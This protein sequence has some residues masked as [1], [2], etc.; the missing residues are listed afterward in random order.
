MDFVDTSVAISENRI[1]AQHLLVM[2]MI[3]LS[4]DRLR[5]SRLAEYKEGAKN[6]RTLTDIRF[7]LLGLLPVGT[8]L[9]TFSTGW[10]SNGEISVPYRFS[11]LR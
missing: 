7:K 11:V 8:A 10:A 1:S 4:E 3:S 6:F 2:L 5:E 9:G